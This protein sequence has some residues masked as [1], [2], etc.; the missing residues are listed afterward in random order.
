MRTIKA[1]NTPQEGFSGYS[2]TA[3]PSRPSGND[4]IFRIK[5]LK[6]SNKI[7]FLSH[8]LPTNLHSDAQCEYEVLEAKEIQVITHWL[9]TTRWKDQVCQNWRFYANYFC[10]L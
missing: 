4:F 3:L 1:S 6:K 9:W 10:Q 5:T 2:L 7:N 8:P